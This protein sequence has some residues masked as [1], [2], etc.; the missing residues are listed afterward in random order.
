MRFG[1]EFLER[2]DTGPPH[3]LCGAVY[4]GLRA[5]KSGVSGLGRSSSKCGPGRA[6]RCRPAR[7]SCLMLSGSVEL[8]DAVKLLDVSGW[9]GV[10]F[11]PPQA[12]FGEFLL[13]PSLFVM[14][15]SEDRPE[16]DWPC[17]T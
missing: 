17:R 4:S 3:Q 16:F 10:L 9:V 1:L 14:R 15:R 13:K 6:P 11:P 5:S 8:L 12:G 2:F 7:A